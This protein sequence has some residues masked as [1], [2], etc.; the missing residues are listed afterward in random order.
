MTT[1]RHYFPKKIKTHNPPEDDTTYKS[2]LCC[3]TTSKTISSSVGSAAEKGNS[4]KDKQ[5]NNQKPIC[6]KRKPH[7]AESL[8]NS[9]KKSATNP[10]PQATT[11]SVSNEAVLLHFSIGKEKPKRSKRNTGTQTTFSPLTQTNTAP[12]YLPD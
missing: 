8:V 6:K 1:I 10:T 11:T 7:T 2:T 12:L 5:R 9:F 3:P 4:N